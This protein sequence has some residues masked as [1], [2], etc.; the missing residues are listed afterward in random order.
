[1]AEKTVKVPPFLRE[2]LEAAQARLGALEEDTQRVLRDLLVK[3]KEG[4]RE[5]GELVQRLSKQDWTVDEL[6]ARLGKLRTQGLELAADWRDRARA[7]AAERL[8]DLQAKAIAFLG[9]ATREQVE[10][11]SR[12]LARLSKRLEARSPRKAHRRAEGA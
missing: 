6:R 3:G 1:M 11:L 2:P 8:V 4:R 7:E 9:V 5:I 12:D 10:Q